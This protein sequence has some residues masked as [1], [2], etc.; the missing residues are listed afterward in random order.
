MDLTRTAKWLGALQALLPP[1]RAISR[2]PHANVTKLLEGM[3]APMGE[4]ERLLDAWFVQ[5]DPNLAEEDGMLPDWERLLGLPDCCDHG[6][7][8]TLE[9]RRMAV[10]EK[11]TV[12]GGAS[13]QYFIDMMARRGIVITIDELGNFT[14]RVNAPMVNLRHFRVGG[15]DA[16]MGKR[17]RYWGDPAME[18]RITRLKPAH[19]K[20]IY[21]YV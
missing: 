7:V 14:W 11:L 21:G 9:Q 1:G 12:L 3:A 5:Y 10:I 8:Q 19:T 2:E 4:A 15:D 18:C 13:R 17:L 16:R 20:V 6:I